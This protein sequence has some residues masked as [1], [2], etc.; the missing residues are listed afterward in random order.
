M[1]TTTQQYQFY[2]TL[3]NDVTNDI[4]KCI[5][6]YIEHMH[7]DKIID[8]DTKRFLIQT[9]PKP[10]RFYI[11]PKVHKQGNPVDLLSLV[12]LTLWNVSHSL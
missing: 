3:D 10:G 2:K 4:Q 1:S 7:R 5:R 12:T 8:D 9:H 11:L 6:I